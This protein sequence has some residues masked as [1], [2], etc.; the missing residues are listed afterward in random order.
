MKLTVAGTFTEVVPVK[1]EI[2]VNPVFTQIKNL[3][4]RRLFNELIEEA[5]QCLIVDNSLVERVESRTSHS[6]YEY[7]EC[8][9]VYKTVRSMRDVVRVKELTQEQKDL[10]MSFSLIGEHLKEMV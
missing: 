1:L 2:D 10:F 9:V 8:E 3:A 6:W 4:F 7:Q 5:D